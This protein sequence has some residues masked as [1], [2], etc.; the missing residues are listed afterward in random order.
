LGASGGAATYRETYQTW[1]TSP[2]GE[3]DIPVSLPYEPGI[4]TAAVVV[5]DGNLIGSQV[6][7]F[8]VSEP[9]KPLPDLYIERFS[10]LLSGPNTYVR[11]WHDYASDRTYYRSKLLG[12]QNRPITITARVRNGGSLPVTDNFAVSFY[13]GTPGDG[14]TLIVAETVDGLAP[15]A[16]ENVRYVWTPTQTRTYVIQVVVDETDE[17][18]ESNEINNYDAYYYRYQACFNDVASRRCRNAAH[19]DI[20][21]V[22]AANPDLWAFNL[23]YVEPVITDVVTMTVEAHNIGHRDVM[24]TEAFT[25]TVYDGYPN[26]DLASTRVLTAPGELGLQ[27]VNG[28]MYRGSYRT[29]DVVWD[30]GYAGTVPG[31]HDICVEV[32]TGAEI[33]EELEENNVNCWDVYV[34]PDESDLYPN[35]LT[36]SNN[37]PLPNEEIEITAWFENRGA[38][39]FTSTEVVTF[40]HRSI[41]P[42]N[43]ITAT[44]PVTITGPIAGHR[45]ISKTHPITWRT[46]GSHGTAYIYVEYIKK[47][48]SYNLG[49]HR[50]AQRL[51]IRKNPSPNLRILSRDIHVD[52]RSPVSGEDVN[53]SVE[54]ANVSRSSVA[55]ATN[56]IVEFHTSGPTAGYHELGQ[57]QTIPSLGPGMVTT[58]QAGETFTMADEFYAVQ[59][60]AWPRVEQGDENYGDNEATTSILRADADMLVFTKT[61]GIVEG[62]CGDTDVITVMAGAPVYYCYQMTNQ[63]DVRLGVHDL[64]DEQLGDVLSGYT[65]D[66]LPGETFTRTELAVLKG[67]PPGTAT[68]TA[69]TDPYAFTATD[70]TMVNV[71]HLIYLPLVLK[72]SQN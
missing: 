37:D 51:N 30:T 56:F 2:S 68:W 26:I 24:T 62:V 13:D 12:V 44:N 23:S 60:S 72:G 66:L 67:T 16:W 21:D 41:A 45:G 36:Y 65:F 31:P 18:T 34:F 1:T 71:R 70:V 58:V 59:V 50:H 8:A 28:P 52:P 49:P 20:I 43:V 27:R 40:Y 38:Q 53:V 15:G 63:G 46:Y 69:S 19:R 11:T 61:V 22:R 64:F 39:P 55:T 35:R 6:I 3:Y 54:I 47:S 7:S 42:E 57:L 5:D 14:G 29:F 17:I 10:V 4:Y 32:D 9:P 33:D 25:L 48:G